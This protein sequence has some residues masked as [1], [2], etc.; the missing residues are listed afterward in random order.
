MKKVVVGVALIVLSLGLLVFTQ[1]SK[2][3]CAEIY[4]DYGPLNG[5]AKLTQCID[6][7]GEIPALE[8]LKLANLE[9]QGT[10]QYG[11]AVVCRVNEFPDASVESCEGMPPEKAYWAILIKEYEHFPNPFDLVGEWGWAQTGIDQITIHNGDSIGLVF[12]NNGEVK[13]P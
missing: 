11:N 10:Q 8:V 13:F 5:G 4:V 3:D 9:I 7:E 12:A 1:Q 6:I 2:T